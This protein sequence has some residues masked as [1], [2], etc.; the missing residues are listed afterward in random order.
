MRDLSQSVAMAFR[1][2]VESYTTTLSPVT[3]N[4]KSITK[5]DHDPGYGEAVRVHVAFEILY[6]IMF[7]VPEGHIDIEVAWGPDNGVDFAVE[8]LVNS[9][10]SFKSVATGQSPSSDVLS[11]VDIAVKVSFRALNVYMIN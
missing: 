2:L 7:S 6:N 8:M 11:A 10:K 5:E 1:Q 4:T 9:Q 3:G